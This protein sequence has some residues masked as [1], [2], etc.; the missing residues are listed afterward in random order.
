VHPVAEVQATPISWLIT[1]A[2]RGVGWMAQL[3]PSHRSAR[4]WTAPEES[5]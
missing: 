3:V 2:G 4:D 1:P 5:M